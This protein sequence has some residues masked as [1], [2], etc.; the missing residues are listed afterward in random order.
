MSSLRN[1]VSQVALIITVAAGL[2]SAGGTP[3]FADSWSIKSGQNIGALVPAETRKLPDGS[4]Y[5]SGGSKQLVVTEDPS[6]PITGQ[7][8]E[9]RWICKI[10][11][12]GADGACV[13]MCAGVDK[14]G[15]L[16]SFRALS[17]GPGKYE[18]GPGTGKYAGATGGGTFEP[19][20]ADDPALAYTVWKGTL[21]LK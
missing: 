12:G 15:D 7:S 18:V 13:T 20:P 16:F 14:D 19:G 8:M 3:A 6:Y 21:K 2:V 17:F 9:C 4:T 11:D 10:N 1:L 5:V